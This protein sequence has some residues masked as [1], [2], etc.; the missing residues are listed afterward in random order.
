[1]LISDLTTHSS[2]GQMFVERRKN[3]STGVVELWWCDWKADGIGPAKKVQIRKIK[4]EPEILT[5][6]EEVEKK[7]AICWSY[8]HTVGNVAV[9]SQ[10]ILGFF[11]NNEG[12]N[13]IIPCDFVRAGKFRIGS[14]RWWCRT[15]QTYWGTKADVASYENSHVMKCSEHNKPMSYVLSPFTIDVSEHEEVGVWCSM[16]AAIST[17]PIP[18]RPPRIHVHVRPKAGGPKRVDRD[19][20]AISVIYT[21]SQGLFG[22]DDISLVNITPPS[23]FEFVVALEAKREM[24]CVNCGKCGYPHLDLGD[25]ARIPHKKHYCGNCGYDSTHSKGKII[26][27]PLQPLHDEFA[28]TL[29]YEIPARTLNLDMK[30]YKECTY[31][32]WASTPAVVWNAARPQELGIHVHV[33]RGSERIIDETFGEVI[34][35]GKKLD[36]LELV[37]MMQARSII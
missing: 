25:F 3:A 22:N 18:N 15:H 32:I 2:G 35:Y 17:S 26:S 28:K 14:E 8:G 34:L 37:E 31:T 27:T 16:P 19:F 12:D 9:F 13:A 23:A 24:S 6:K 11:P 5:A 21:D 1:M 4:D 30:Q 29:K 20:Q 7:S 33:H 10:E 36:R